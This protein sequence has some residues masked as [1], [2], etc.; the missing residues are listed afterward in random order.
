MNENNTTP[1][2]KTETTEYPLTPFETFIKYLVLF[3][4]WF[5]IFF[6]PGFIIGALNNALKVTLGAIPTLL[7]YSPF[8]WFLKKASEKWSKYYNARI[9]KKY[10]LK[11]SNNELRLPDGCHSIEENRKEECS[12]EEGKYTPK[13]NES[14]A[15]SNYKEARKIA[16]KEY[17]EKKKELKNIYPKSNYKSYKIATIVLSILLLGATIVNSAQFIYYEEYTS[18][19]FRENL[20][21]QTEIRDLKCYIEALEDEIKHL[22]E[23]KDYY[24]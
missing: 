14:S 4:I 10:T 21:L 6:V 19:L 11:K 24:W 8:C 17:K 3:F 12:E 1:L 7:I 2:S 18:E 13:L 15:E 9:I 22:R 5:G 23:G 20:D 16:K